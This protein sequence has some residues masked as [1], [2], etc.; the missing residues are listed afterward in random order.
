MLSFFVLHNLT[1]Y[2]EKKDILILTILIIGFGFIFYF[3]SG[4][5]ELINR[6][7]YHF[8]GIMGAELGYLG[9]SIHLDPQV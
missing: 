2:E 9:I 6:P 7:I 4:L 8:Y 5:I 3:F 1:D